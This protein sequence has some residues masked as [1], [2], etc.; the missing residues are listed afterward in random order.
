[1]KF[2]EIISLVTGVK[3]G[4]FVTVEKIGEAKLKK[5]GNPLKDSKVEKE[6]V[7]Q[8]RLGCDTQKIENKQAAREGRTPREIGPLPWGEYI[9][10]GIPVIKHKDQLYLRGYWVKSLESNYKVDGKPAT[11]EQLA[12]I[13]QFASKSSEFSSS[14]PLCIKFDNIR[15]IAGGGQTIS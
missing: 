8:I 4:G 6:S 9:A 13:K 12:I 11:A 14:S 1:M 7:F 5:T 10:D 2:R 3:S 15:R